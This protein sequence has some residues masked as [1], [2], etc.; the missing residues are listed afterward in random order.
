MYAAPGWLARAVF[1]AP[2]VVVVSTATVPGMR[3]LEGALH[4]LHTNVSVAVAVVGPRR[5]PRWPREVAHS[6]GERTADAD[7][8]GALIEVRRDP[9]LS[10]RGLDTTPL[11]SAV[12]A[13]ASHILH[14]FNGPVP[15]PDTKG[16]HL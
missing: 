13:S 15:T 2:Q 1:G 16:K 4:L 6:M 10:V 7:Q 9:A 3:R 8:T 5:R 12:L 14:W 11:P